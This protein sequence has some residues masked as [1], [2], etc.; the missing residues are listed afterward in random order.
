[1]EVPRPEVKPELQQLAYAIATP[2]LSCVCNL[3][4]SSRQLQILKPLS[5]ARD[6]TCALMDT[7]Q[8]LIF[9]LFFYF[10]RV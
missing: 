10:I 8:M 7:S 6:Q 3:S 2:V 5:E 4:R 9:G 1:M